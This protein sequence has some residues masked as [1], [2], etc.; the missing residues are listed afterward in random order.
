MKK[1]LFIFPLVLAISFN[2]AAQKSESEIAL[3]EYFIDAEFFLA[4]DYYVDALSDFLQV[5]KS[6]LPGYLPAGIQVLQ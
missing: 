2:I 1:I 6:C 4:Q 5:Y 3:R